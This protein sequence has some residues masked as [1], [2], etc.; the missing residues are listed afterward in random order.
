M[1]IDIDMIIKYENGE[2]DEDEVV[3][4]FQRLVDTGIIH[5][6]Q[7]SY[8]RMARHLIEAGLVSY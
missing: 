5:Q 4:L 2:L 3:V 1:A 6:L 8:V 7:G